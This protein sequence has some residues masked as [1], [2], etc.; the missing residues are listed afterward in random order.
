VVGYVQR[1]RFGDAV[2]LLK[3]DSSDAF[4]PWASAAGGRGH[5]TNIVD[6]GLKVLFSVF[7]CY[8]SVF[9]S[10]PAPWK[11]FCR[12]PCFEQIIKKLSDKV[13]NVEVMRLTHVRTKIVTQPSPLR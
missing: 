11:F 12:R 10:L 7:F 8:F 13:L 3:K 1:C 6:R 4:E 9:F 2:E 5:G